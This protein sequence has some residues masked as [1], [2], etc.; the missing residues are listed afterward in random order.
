[1]KT[2]NFTIVG[3]AAAISLTSISSSANACATTTW[4][5][6]SGNSL[7]S[8]IRGRDCGGN[9]SVRMTGIFGDTGWLPLYKNGA[10]NYKAQYGDGQVLT[11]ISMKTSGSAMSAYFVH[12]AAGGATSNT[13]GQYVLTGF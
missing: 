8:T 11:D 1:M 3:L 6:T 9:M 13:Q 5:K 12:K 7:A 4:K 2:L 10:T